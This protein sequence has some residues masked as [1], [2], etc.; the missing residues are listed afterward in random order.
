VKINLRKLNGGSH[1]KIHRCKK[2]LIMKDLKTLS[3][4]GEV[5]VIQVQLDNNKIM[6]LIKILG[7]I[8][9]LNQNLCNL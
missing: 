1:R 4:V 3:V 2:R 5:D 7:I 9:L 8:K 6:K